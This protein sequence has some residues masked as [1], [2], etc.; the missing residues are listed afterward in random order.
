[1]LSEPPDRVVYANLALA[2]KDFELIESLARE[3][4]ILDAS[5][6]FEDYTDTRFSDKTQKAQAYSFEPT[7]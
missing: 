5:V 2:R 3:A 1:M 4:G 6:A 7:K